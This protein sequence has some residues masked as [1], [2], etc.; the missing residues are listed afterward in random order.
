M[1]VMGI[2]GAGKG[3]KRLE[4]AGRGARV[5]V[6]AMKKARHLSISGSEQKYL[7]AYGLLAVGN[8]Q[9]A[10]GFRVV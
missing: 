8:G 4:E 6:A 9:A 2:R 5:K 1:A 7:T 10:C 3:W